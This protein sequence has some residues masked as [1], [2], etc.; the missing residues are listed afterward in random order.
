MNLSLTNQKLRIV[1]INVILGLILI[2][3]YYHYITNSGVPVKTLWGKAYK[4]EKVYLVSML[5]AAIGYLLVFTFSVF[6]TPNT[7]V[8]S[9]ILSNLLVIQVVIVVVSMIWLPMTLTYLKDK[10]NKRLNMV[11]VLIILFI[12]AL[13]SA[14]QFLLVRNLT[15]E[16]NY[17]GK[18]MKTLAKL[19]A[20]YFFVHTFFFDFIGWDLGFFSK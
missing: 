1:A 12:V 9:G 8:N 15:P 20:G 18:T 5:L 3:S 19:G 7:N 6:K 14:K 17:C 2:Y 11:A 10:S 16:N 4:V 13:A